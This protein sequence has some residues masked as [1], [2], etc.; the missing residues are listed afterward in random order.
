MQFL[1]QGFLIGIIF[2]IPVGTIGAM[3][4]QK[5]LKYGMKAGVMTGLG[6]SIADSLYAIIGAFGLTF[7]SDFLFQHE[8][9]INCFGGT[10]LV[11]MGMSMLREKEINMQIYDNQ[12][13]SSVRLFL[14]SFFVGLTNP[15][16][17]LTFLFAFTYF[18]IPSYLDYFDGTCLVF[19]VF[20]GT[21]FW[22]IA[23]AASLEI[24]K[25]KDF[26]K[27]FGN[28]DMWFGVIYIL[29]GAFVFIR[30]IQLMY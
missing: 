30:V 5:T 1:W 8:I 14:P 19:G 2:G 22:W 27:N 3:A 13:I 23:L 24:I 17:I 25:K 10:L 21:L 9:L 12:S 29:L 11:L 26:L 7:I 6:S 18:R 4:M 20:L 28:K 15:V 16:V